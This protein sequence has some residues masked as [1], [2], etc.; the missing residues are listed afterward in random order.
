MSVFFSARKKLQFFFSKVHCS[1][2]LEEAVFAGTGLFPSQL[3]PFGNG[4]WQRRKLGGLGIRG[5]AAFHIFDVNGQIPMQPPIPR[6]RLV[7]WKT[8]MPEVMVLSVKMTWFGWQFL[9][10]LG[11]G[12]LRLVVK[13]NPKSLR[14]PLDVLP[15]AQRFACGFD[16]TCKQLR[17]K[18]A[19]L[20]Y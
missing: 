5:K 11:F 15:N 2:Y 7:D 17:A 13:K 10:G 6:Q 20:R 1:Q 14:Y 3:F 16:T 4:K 12:G 9:F 19:R 8:M 18:S